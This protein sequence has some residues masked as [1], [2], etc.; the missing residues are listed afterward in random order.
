LVRYGLVQRL[1]GKGAQ[2]SARELASLEI[3]QTYSF[4][5]PGEGTSAGAS[6]LAA[7]LGTLDTTL[8][9]I[10]GAGLNLDARA[11]WDTRANQ[12]V[13]TSLTANWTA[14]DAAV[15]VSLF[16]SN[17]VVPKPSPGVDVPS[18]RSSQVRFFGGAPIVRRLLRIDLQANYDITN[19][20]ML[21]SRTL[22]T[23]ERSCYKVLV[24]YRDLRIGTV[25]S[26]DFRLALNLKNIGSFLDFTGSL[27]R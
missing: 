19:G 18:A 10:A 7:R 8:R 25:P 24:E 12:L 11:S 1:L 17:P 9:A 13:A 23:F 4:R 15:A 21:E 5:L 3:A 2:G 14:G 20:K 16:Q 22:L 26:R 6:P 27:S